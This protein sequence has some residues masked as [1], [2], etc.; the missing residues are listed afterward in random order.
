MSKHEPVKSRLA[1]WFE[2]DEILSFLHG[3]FKLHEKLDDKTGERFV[4]ETSL[5]L[6]VGIVSIFHMI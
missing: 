6:G 4:N 2:A 1:R 3:G 5:S